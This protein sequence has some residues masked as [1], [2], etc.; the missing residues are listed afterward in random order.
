VAK[1]RIG[2]LLVQ[3]DVGL[4]SLAAGMKRLDGELNR[5]NQKLDKFIS[6]QE[7]RLRTAGKKS[8][9]KDSIFSPAWF[10][11]RARW[12]VQLRAFWVLWQQLSQ[13][14]K[15]AFEFEQEMANVRAITQATN[16]QFVKLTAKALEVGK[17]TRFSAKEAAE[18]MVVMS[19][20]G[21]SVTEVLASIR[22]VANLATA[23]LFE[24]KETASLVVTI[25]RAWK[26]DASDAG[27]ITDILATAINKTKLT[28]E[29]LAT[30]FNF[31]AGL[32]PQLNITLEETTALMGI[33]ANRGLSASTAATSLRAMMAA[34]LS[35]TDKFKKVLREV[36]LTVRDVDPRFHEMGTILETLRTAGFGAAEA[37][38]AFRRRAAAG[39]AILIG[40]SKEFEDLATSMHQVGRAAQMAEINLDTVSGQAK[41]FEDT[42][43]ALAATLMK[44]IDPAL[45]LML[46]GLKEIFKVV[47]ELIKPLAE[48]VGL[49][50]KHAEILAVFLSRGL[51]GID[52]E[53]FVNDIREMS[54]T[55]KQSTDKI[56]DLT[57]GW[58]KLQDAQNEVR[59]LTA[60]AV[61]AEK[62]SEAEDFIKKALKVAIN[63]KTITAGQAEDIAALTTVEEQRLAIMK[64]V[65]AQTE[66]RRDLLARERAFE[67]A[68]VKIFKT[69]IAK[70]TR[71]E[72]KKA[73]QRLL[74][75]KEEL[76]LA[77]EKAK[78]D[79]KSKK[80][81]GVLP[82]GIQAVKDILSSAK[83]D[84]VKSVVEATVEYNAAMSELFRIIRAGG[85]EAAA[86]LDGMGA[87]FVELK[88][89]IFEAGTSEEVEA[90]LKK[91]RLDR[92]VPKGVLKESIE[93]L[94]KAAG[95]ARKYGSAYKKTNKEIVEDLKGRKALLDSGS[96]QCFRSRNNRY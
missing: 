22:A 33:L 41:Q 57:N 12:F 87:E 37:F 71:E 65:N 35:P 15:G 25:M 89:A 16:E 79:E 44:D 51:A 26:K 59:Q 3:I 24:F 84:E 91:F 8:Q 77:E 42:L 66:R 4:S 47:V 21:M 95:E 60:D 72:G 2:N 92:A 94:Q 13:A 29:A 85:P 70:A 31:I 74:D 19:Q 67:V 18:G 1:A 76:K 78:L 54:D 40:A 49:A 56:E 36:G 55:V 68:R 93:D 32:A 63:V 34:L 14:V 23:T 86:T 50:A 39:A 90:V 17:T 48:F 7:Q 58:R 27:E 61:L 46:K 28:M 9:G 53:K 75:A 73:F 80:V 82:F 10:K 20:A 96:Y 30:G 62:A 83:G 88:E 69:E 43:I 81:K 11:S 6:K 5:S 64:L 45:K 52:T 38:R